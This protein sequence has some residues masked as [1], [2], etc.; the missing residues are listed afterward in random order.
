MMQPPY[1]SPC[2]L[3]LDCAEPSM[4]SGESPGESPCSSTLYLTTVWPEIFDGANF[5]GFRVAIVVHAAAGSI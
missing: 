5:R 3:L 1:Y 4:L 2:L